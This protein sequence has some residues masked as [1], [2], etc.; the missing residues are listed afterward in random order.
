MFRPVRMTRRAPLLAGGMGLLF[1]GVAYGQTAEWEPP[2]QHAAEQP[3]EIVQLLA[4]ARMWAQKNRG[5]LERQL[6]NKALL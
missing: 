6:L 5:D 4:N 3:D 1:G 2:E